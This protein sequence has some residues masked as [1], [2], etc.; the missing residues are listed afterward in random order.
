MKRTIMESLRNISKMFKADT[1]KTTIVGFMLSLFFFLSAGVFLAGTFSKPVLAADA[2]TTTLNSSPNPA[3]FGADVTF[4]AT[5]TSGAGTPT[6]NVEFRDLS[7]GN[8]LLGVVPLNGSGQAQLVINNLAVGLHQVVAI[9]LGFDNFSGSTSLPVN[10]SIITAITT[11]TLLTAPNPSTFGDTVTFT[12]T[13][14]SAAGTPTVGTII[15]FDGATPVSPPIAI[16]PSGVATFTISTLAVGTHPIR[17]VYSGGGNFAGS[18][19]NIVNH[20]VGGAATTTVVTSDPNP[21][22]FGQTVTFTA[23]VTSV[24]TGTITG[25]VEF[26]DNGTSIGTGTLNASGEATITTSSLNVGTHPI[27]GTFTTAPGGNYSNSTSTPPYN[28]VVTAA[29]TAISVTSSPNP[30]VL[31]QSVTFTATVTS[32]AGAPASGTVEFYDNGSLIGTGTVVTGGIATF[33]TTALTEGTHPITVTFLTSGNYNGSTSTPPY[34]HVVIAST[35]TAVTTDPN[36]SVVGQS[37]TFTATVTASSGTATGTVEFYDGATLLGT[38]TLNGAGAAT[39]VTDT[40]TIGTHTIT[41]KYLGAANFGASTSP[42]HTHTVNGTPT[43]TVLASSPP[44]IVYGETVF[45]TAT[46]TSGAGTP[47]GTVN[48]NEGASILGSGTLDG[49]GVATFNTS[50]LGV[51]THVITAT[52]QASGNFAGSTSNTVNVD[53][54]T[55]TTSITFTVTPNPANF[56]QNVTLNATVSIVAPGGGTLAGTVEFRNTTNGNFLLGSALVNASGQASI[57]TSS[58]FLLGANDIRVIYLG[59]PNYLSSTS[60]FITLQVNAANTG[61]SLVSSLNP[62]IVGQNVTFIATVTSTLGTP[63]GTVNFFDNG[64]QIGSGTLSGGI[65]NFSTTGLTVGSHPITATYTGN[66]GFSPATSSQLNQVVNKANTTTTLISSP[67]PSVLG[68]S[69]SFTATVAIVAP[70]TGTLTGSFV[71]FFDGA[72]PLGTLAL[73]AGGQATLSTTTLPQGTRSIT[74]VFLG[75]ATLNTSTSNVVSQQN[76]GAPVYSSQPAPGS[77]IALGD[78]QLN[79]TSTGSL[80]ISNTGNLNLSVSTPS[81]IAAPFSISFANPFVLTPNT[82]RTVNITCQPTVLG[83]FSATLSYTTDDTTKPTVTYT[84]TCNGIAPPEASFFRPITPGRLYDSRVNTPVSEAIFGR[85]G[86]ISTGTVRTIKATEQLNVPAQAT[87][88]MAN[89]TVVNAQGGGNLRAFPANLNDVNTATVNWYNSSTGPGPRVVANFII[90]SLDS[91][92][93]F[94][95][96]VTGTTD[97]IVDVTGYLLNNPNGAGVYKP[98][99]TGTNPRLYDSRPAGTRNTAITGQGTGLLKTGQPARTLKISGTG[100]LQSIPASASAVIVNVTAVDSE[101]GGYFTIYPGSSTVPKV[102][103]VNWQNW[104]TAGTNIPRDVANMAVVP[105][106][107]NGEISIIAGGTTDSGANIV[108]DVLGYIDTAIGSSSGFYLPLST[109]LRLYDSRAT[110][111]TYLG[112]LEKGTL[113]SQTTR[114]IQGNGV[115]SVPTTAKSV[116]IRISTVEV[117]G[118][119]F[120][121]LYPAEPYLGNSNVNTNAQFQQIGNLAVVQLEALGNFLVRN[122]S[123]TAAMGFVIDIIAYFN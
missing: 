66:T 35:T 116:L 84:I 51:G 97:F 38:G 103:N 64:I 34:N 18:T 95:V 81:G 67:N 30:S 80:L 28:H 26:F 105:L 74:A 120:F 108:I 46:V 65:A 113:A 2:T 62:S 3:N 52:Y 86:P 42:N 32:G 78:V 77:T 40:L 7:N 15:F 117:G 25:S 56:G 13:V 101:G 8:A 112:S 54:I 39:F 110:E 102:S 82:S 93:S 122:G 96:A 57:T 6:G 89:I 59:N 16:N 100:G 92:G 47:T 63:T 10:Q 27:T 58:G 43:T 48:F 90:L 87:A 31:A 91:T 12:A 99:N 36:P 20:E 17:A 109:Q 21:S 1:R 41:A 24:V 76:G 29:S 104:R 94:K 111:P 5:V 114:A 107:T 73:N 121:A 61:I 123:N 118:G 70:G 22:V 14:T 9:Y 37:V 33:T 119:G 83:S 98:L 55:A 19:S 75:N 72:T 53:V 49:S 60:G 88:I 44:S 115:L 106:N 85:E 23:T 45:F 71:Q 50:T 68:G 69:V 11:N 79:A 4:T